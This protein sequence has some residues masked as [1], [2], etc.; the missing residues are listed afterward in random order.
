MTEELN[1][2]IIINNSKVDKTTFSITL[3]VSLVMRI[4]ISRGTS[5]RAKWIQKVIEDTLENEVTVDKMYNDME[6]MYNEVK[7]MKEELLIILNSK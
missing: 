5:S 6:Q 2:D 1:N 7:K 4:D 3:P